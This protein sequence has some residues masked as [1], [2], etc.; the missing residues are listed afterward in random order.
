ML[1]AFLSSATRRDYVIKVEA[2]WN[3]FTGFSTR[4]DVADATFRNL[5]AVD[6]HAFVNR[7]ILEDVRLSWDQ[8][9]TVRD[10]VALLKNAVNIASEVYV[11]RNKRRLARQAI[12]ECRKL[13]GGLDLL[14][15]LYEERIQTFEAEPPDADWDGVFVA[16][17]K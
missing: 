9:A 6:N 16:T 7:K 12:T 4:A 5:A 2:R 17:S 1:T 10:R 14:Y 11:A 3:L 13:N 15:D 8:L